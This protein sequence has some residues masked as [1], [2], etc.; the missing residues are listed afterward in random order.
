MVGGRKHV[1][2]AQ[3]RYDA[4]ALGRYDALANSTRTLGPPD[5]SVL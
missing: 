2:Q 1:S 3:E 5:V 4:E